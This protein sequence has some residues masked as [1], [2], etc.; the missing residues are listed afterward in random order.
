ML[1]RLTNAELIKVGREI[2]LDYLSSN[3]DFFDLEEGRIP[4]TAEYP[5]VMDMMYYELL[6]TLEE[7]EDRIRLFNEGITANRDDKDTIN[8]LKEQLLII[9]KEKE[10]FENSCMQYMKDLYQKTKV[11]DYSR[12]IINIPLDKKINSYYD[13]LVLS[14]M[15]YDDI[16]VMKGK[17]NEYKALTTKEER[18]KF[19]KENTEVTHMCFTILNAER[20]APVALVSIKGSLDF[21]GSRLKS[22]S[23]LLL[24]KKYSDFNTLTLADTMEIQNN[25]ISQLFQS[26]IDLDKEDMKVLANTDIRGDNYQLLSSSAFKNTNYWLGTSEDQLFIRY[27]CPSTQRVYYNKI[28]K[29]YLEFSEFFKNGD[30]ISYLESWWNICHMGANPRSTEK[31]DRC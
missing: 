10:Y 2:F 27:V 18:K 1:K 20:N 30:Y 12:N 16:A 4:C 17:Y 3:E 5:T 26:K 7:N 15:F 29:E 14:V 22:S 25:D 21:E 28:N 9:L 23:I 24:D 31:F 8:L 19:I 13:D 6:K 11:I